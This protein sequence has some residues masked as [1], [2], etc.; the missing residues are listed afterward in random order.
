M[1]AAG[2]QR[3]QQGG[4]AAQHGRKIVVF[5]LPYHYRTSLLR[6]EP[7]PLPQRLLRASFCSSFLLFFFFARAHGSAHFKIYELQ[8]INA[9]Y[10]CPAAMPSQ[11]TLAGFQSSSLPSLRAFIHSASAICTSIR[12]FFITNHL[13]VCFRSYTCMCMRVRVL[14]LCICCSVLAPSP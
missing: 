10:A 8:Q 12:L 6:I 11:L 4:N 13:F 9:F 7:L 14:W 2:L 1:P 5:T 3:G